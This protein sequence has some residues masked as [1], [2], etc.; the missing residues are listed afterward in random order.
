M[1]WLFHEVGDLLVGK[2]IST[3]SHRDTPESIKVLL[4]DY[5]SISD[6]VFEINS[7]TYYAY[8]LDSGKALLLELSLSKCNPEYEEQYIK[9]YKEL[10]GELFLRSTGHHL[11]QEEDFLH[12]GHQVRVG[13][14]VLEVS[15]KPET[16][17]KTVR[18]FIAKQNELEQGLGLRKKHLYPALYA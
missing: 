16:E 9:R 11:P 7:V 10:I 15:D 13:D 6:D 3:R 5:V 14:F 4:S 2:G 12:D 17:P 18:V 1:S 8:G